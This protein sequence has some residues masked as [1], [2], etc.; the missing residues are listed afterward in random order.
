MNH[1][2]NLNVDPMKFAK[3]ISDENNKTIAS[4]ASSEGWNVKEPIANQRLTSIPSTIGGSINS[5]A[6]IAKTTKKISQLSLRQI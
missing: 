6:S 4:F 2:S 3:S 1:L 5:T